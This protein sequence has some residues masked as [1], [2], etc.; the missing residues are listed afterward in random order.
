[1]SE[2]PDGENV[3]KESGLSDG[4]MRKIRQIIA[5]ARAEQEQAAKIEY[6]EKLSSLRSTARWAL[7]SLHDK[8]KALK[9]YRGVEYVGHKPGN[10][11]LSFRDGRAIGFGFAD[12]ASGAASYFYDTFKFWGFQGPKVLYRLPRHLTDEFFDR[13]TAFVEGIYG[14][15]VIELEQLMNEVEAQEDPTQLALLQLKAEDLTAKTQSALATIAESVK[16]KARQEEQASLQVRISRR[17]GALRFYLEEHL[18]S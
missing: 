14:K 13:A 9:E 17:I 5:R 16:S 1:M 3:E 18:S 8:C 4:E 15:D 11:I 12:G 6:Y 2:R 7:K 10:T